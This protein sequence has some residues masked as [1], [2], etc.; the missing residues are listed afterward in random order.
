MHRFALFAA[1]FAVACEGD[2]DKESVVDTGM[3]GGDPIAVTGIA[4]D[5]GDTDVTLTPS[6]SGP[7]ADLLLTAADFANTGVFLIEEN[8]FPFDAMGNP[9]ALSLTLAAF[10]AGAGETAFDCANHY[11]ETSPVMVYVVRAYD[12]ADVLA[13]CAAGSETAGDD[14]GFLDD[15]GASAAN[16]MASNPDQFVSCETDLAITY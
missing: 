8:N 12:S 1:F 10:P 15:E 7:V 11:D 2:S 13:D 6:A 14:Q 4:V 16:G 3:N 5:C 9:D